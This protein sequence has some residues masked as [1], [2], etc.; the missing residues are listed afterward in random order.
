[1]SGD[2]TTL[3]MSFPARGIPV[4]YSMDHSRHAHSNL[5]KIL[6]SDIPTEFFNLIFKNKIPITFTLFT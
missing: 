3:S 1:M 2:M 4:L 5:N 6:F